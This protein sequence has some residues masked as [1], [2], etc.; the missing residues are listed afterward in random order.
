MSI[1]KFQEQ[2]LK[3]IPENLPDL[4]PLNSN[5]SHAPKRKDILNKQEKQLALK[6]ALGIFLKISTK[7]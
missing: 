1:S 6:N 3:G 5:L 4:Q 2:I 7:F